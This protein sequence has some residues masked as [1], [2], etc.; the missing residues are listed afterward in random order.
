MFNIRFCYVYV[1]TTFPGGWGW[2]AIQKRNFFW[3]EFKT[4]HDD[5]DNSFWRTNTTTRKCDHLFIPCKNRIAI[6]KHK[7]KNLLKQD[8]DMTIQP[9]VS[10]SNNSNDNNNDNKDDNKFNSPVFFILIIQS[11][12]VCLFVCYKLFVPVFYFHFLP[13]LFPL[14]PFPPLFQFSR[15]INFFNDLI[16]IKCF[17]LSF[18]NF[19]GKAMTMM[20]IF[21]ICSK[22]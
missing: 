3:G 16:F 12:K 4:R 9:S 5:G 1:T 2:G 14:T 18:W 10:E 17:V 6:S 22:T 7:N 15:Q 11:H 21:K 8:S 20:K 13:P 19:G